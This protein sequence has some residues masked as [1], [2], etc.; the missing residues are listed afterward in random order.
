MTSSLDRWQRWRGHCRSG[1][2]IISNLGIGGYFRLRSARHRRNGSDDH[3]SVA[4]TSRHAKYP[5]QCRP[6]TSDIQVFEHVFVE[7]QFS[8]IDDVGNAGLIVDCG[9]NV[10]YSSAYFLSRFPKC[11]LI[12]IEPE[13]G[14]FALLRTNLQPYGN[15]VRTIQSAV[16]SASKLL[17]I[18]EQLYRDGR[19]WA[20]QV[21]ECSPEEESGFLATDIAS[22][23]R[24]SAHERISILKMDIEGAEA[25]VFS[26]NYQSWIGRVDNLLIELHDDTTFGN[27]SAIF[28]SAIA[29]QGFSI[30]RVGELTVCKRPSSC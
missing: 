8:C 29:G 24:D 6:N 9:A 27:C 26:D 25:V 15:S 2:K 23:L 12:A 16:W 17:A 14:N 28:F 3:A 11:H 5:L 20:R 10:G 22:L 7:R 30:S 18:S 19:E 13:P 21:R 1:M 4:L